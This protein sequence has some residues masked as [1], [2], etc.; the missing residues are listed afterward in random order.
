MQQ[1]VSIC[2]SRFRNLF[3]VVMYC[4]NLDGVLVAGRGGMLGIVRLVLACGPETSPRDMAPK[5][6]PAIAAGL[7]DYA[8][9]L[10]DHDARM[11]SKPLVSSDGIA[12]RPS[13]MH[14]L[15]SSSQHCTAL[16]HFAYPTSLA[17]RRQ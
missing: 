2:L 14:D 6:M 8:G 4:V 10:L 16:A 17:H 12:L 3:D 11:A 5:L 7:S 1:D 13:F 15:S 9:R